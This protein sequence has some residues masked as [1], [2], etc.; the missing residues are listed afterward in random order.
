MKTSTITTALC[1]AYLAIWAGSAAAQT[2]TTSYWEAWPAVKANFELTKQTRLQIY[3]ETENGEDFGYLQWKAGALLNYRMKEIVRPHHRDIDE[4]N[5]YYLV[6]GV[7]YE[8]LDTSS[9]SSTKRENR[10]MIQ[11][12]PR[13]IPFAGVVFQDRNRVEF[14]WVN[15]AYDVRYR[16]KLTVARGFKIDKFRLTPYASGELFWDRKY[17]TWNENQ[18]AFGVQFPYKHRFM[19]DTFYLRQNC[20]TCS[21]DPLNVWGLTLNLYFNRKK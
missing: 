2:T 9:S 3:G 5:E 11:A 20:T 1:V 14:R 21:Q 10:L 13:H 12:T 19:L 16:N 17:H 15:G 7:G 6:L 18:Y 4:E 8:Y